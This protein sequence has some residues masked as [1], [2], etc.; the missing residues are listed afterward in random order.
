MCAEPGSTPYSFRQFE[1]RRQ[2]LSRLAGRLELRQSFPSRPRAE[3]GSYNHDRATRDHLEFQ[4]T[5]KQAH[6]RLSLGSPLTHGRYHHLAG[7]GANHIGVHGAQRRHL[8]ERHFQRLGHSLGSHLQPTG[9]AARAA[10][11]HHSFSRGSRT[12]G[13]RLDWIGTKRGGARHRRAAN[14]S[15]SHHHLRFQRQ[16]HAAAGHSGGVQ[17]GSQRFDRGSTRPERYLRHRHQNQKHATSLLL[18]ACYCG[19]V[20]AACYCGSCCWAVCG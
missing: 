13:G 7:L 1:F 19:P 18:R 10:V 2:P 9:R 14:R 20:T 12:R 6:S 11:R 4:R 15:Q 5:C 16:L 8:R 3:C 17:R